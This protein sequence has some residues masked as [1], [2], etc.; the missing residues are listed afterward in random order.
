MNCVVN[1]VVVLPWQHFDHIVV[2]KWQSIIHHLYSSVSMVTHGAEGKTD[3]TKGK[4]QQGKTS[5]AA[6]FFFCTTVFRVPPLNE[7][8]CQIG[9]MRSNSPVRCFSDQHRRT[10]IVDKL[11]KQRHQTMTSVRTSVCHR[12]IRFKP[13]RQTP[14]TNRNNFE[15]FDPKT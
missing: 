8:I 15:W 7:S 12:G 5:E 13:T 3:M 4:N 14:C 6:S 1:C 11:E 9:S 10:Y 2:Q